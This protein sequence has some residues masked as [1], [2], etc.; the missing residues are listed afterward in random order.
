MIVYNITI[1]VSWTINNEWLR[2]MQEIHIPK[3]LA[4]GCFFEYR[5]LKLLEINE[6]EGPTYAV[7]FHTLTTGNYQRFIDQH[8]AYLRKQLHE[9][10]KEHVVTFSTLM[11]VLH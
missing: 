1:H 3:I 2:W 9:K 11:E 10:W 8:E 5:I 4:T 6:D 7:Q